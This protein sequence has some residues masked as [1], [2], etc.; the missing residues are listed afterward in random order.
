MAAT[1]TQQQEQIPVGTGWIFFHPGLQQLLKVTEV[2]YKDG[3]VLVSV[4]DR[5]GARGR[6]RFDL[7]QGNE[8][9]SQLWSTFAKLCLHAWDM[10]R[11]TIAPA[12]LV[13]CYIRADVSF[14]QT[15]D[16]RNYPRFS[17]YS[18]AP[19]DKNGDVVFNEADR[20]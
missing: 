17:N 14:Y 8:V 15:A 19:F 16:G 11:E 18:E 9:I 2:T 5:R 13:G 4:K 7:S 3:V 1:K 10:Q 6:I 20:F 12:E